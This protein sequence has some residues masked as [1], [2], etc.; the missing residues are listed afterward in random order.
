MSHHVCNT[1]SFAHQPDV[2]QYKQVVV[3][4]ILMISGRN[5]SVSLWESNIGLRLGAMSYPLYSKVKVKQSLY[6]PGQ[7]LRVPGG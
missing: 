6:R 1:L 3:A 5:Y 7:A 2:L 4:E